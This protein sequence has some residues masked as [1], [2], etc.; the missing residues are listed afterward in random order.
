MMKNTWAL[1]E[2]LFLKQFSEPRQGSAKTAASDAGPCCCHSLKI[3]REH[4]IGKG[5]RKRFSKQ[6]QGSTADRGGGG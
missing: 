5:K 1:G 3:R 6:K 4:K 2:R